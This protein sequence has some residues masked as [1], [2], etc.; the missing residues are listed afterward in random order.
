M[1][2]QNPSIDPSDNGSLVGTLRFVFQKL[3]QGVSGMLPAKI[4]SYD[5]DA[6]RAQVEIL[7]AIVGTSGEQVPRPAVASIPVLFLGGGEF[8]LSFPLKPGDLGWICASDRDISIFLKSYGQ[9][10]PNTKRM[11]NFADGLFIPDI[12]RG[13]TIDGDDA[14][15]AVLSNLDGTVKIAL[16]E[17]KIVITAPTVEVNAD[18]TVTIKAPLVTMAGTPNTL[19]AVT[20]DITATGSITPNV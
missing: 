5:R 9:S 20:G 3:M 11:F 18:T 14:D 13:Y 12:M 10:P 17:D 2:N 7:I 15:R 19:L 6:N 1:S 4:T 8:F 16:G